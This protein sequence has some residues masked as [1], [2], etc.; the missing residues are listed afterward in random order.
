MG[1][2]VKRRRD[3]DLASVLMHKVADIRGGVSVAVS[4]LGG[5]WLREGAVLSAPVNGLC[6]V[7]KYAKVVAEVAAAG[8]AINVAKG[9]NFKVG[10]YVMAATQAKAYAITSISTTNKEYDVLNVGTAL[11]AIS[12]GAFVMEAKEESADTASALR[13]TPCAVVG[14]GKPVIAGEN[15]DTDAWV[16]AVTKGNGMPATIATALKGVINI[17]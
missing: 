6:H 12:K 1:M 13:Y 11:G 3:A 4:D 14:T 5:D 8:K 2:T 15:L 17:D 9:H 7:V 16:I 10:D